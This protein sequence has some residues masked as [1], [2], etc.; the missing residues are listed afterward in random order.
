MADPLV[1]SRA[2]HYTATILATGVLSFRGLIAGPVRLGSWNFGVDHQLRLIFWAGLAL[3]FASSA[4]WLL[5]VSAAID[6]GTWGR[7]LA[8][9]TAAMVLT[10]TQFGHIWIVRLVVGMLLGAVVGGAIGQGLW[11]RSFELPLAA[12]FAGSLAFA[13][14]A[15]SAPGFNGDIH[16]LSDAL[17]IIAVC[18]WVGGLVPYALYLGSIDQG[19]RSSFADI[20]DVTRRFSSLG[21]LAVLTIAATGIVNSFYLV[22]SVHLF[23]HTAYGQLLLIKVPL[24]IAMVGVAA[25]NRYRLVPALSRQGA[26]KR[27]RR[28]SLI[29]ACFGLSIICIVSVLGTMPPAALE[30]AM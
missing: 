5:S 29:E 24:F 20:E 22:G 16:L 11:R 27:L 23:T 30:Q 2:L 12:V 1:L 18:A 28:N 9:G 8:D 7:A 4:G 21:M 3:A 17:H 19:S 14:H 13:G 26:V 10:E 15:A 25:I 6:G